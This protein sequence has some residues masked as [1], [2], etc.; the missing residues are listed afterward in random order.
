MCSLVLGGRENV[1]GHPPPRSEYAME[2]N[3]KFTLRLYAK[4]YLTTAVTF[5]REGK[6]LTDIVAMV[7]S[8]FETLAS[9]TFATSACLPL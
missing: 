3:T 2:D 9:T 1:A 5:T 8:C 6:A 4:T 7:S